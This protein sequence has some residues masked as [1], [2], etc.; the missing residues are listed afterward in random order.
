MRFY[1]CLVF[2][3]LVAS[4][5]KD[6]NQP[7]RKTLF[8]RLS[9]SETGISF[10]NAVENQGDF[11][12]FSYRNFYN[13]GGVGIGD[14][15]NDGLVDIY[16]SGNQSPNKLYLNQG[17][18]K[19]KDISKTAG[20]EGNKLWST[21]VTMVDINYDGFLD[22]YVSNAGY[23]KGEDQENELFINNGDLTFTEKASEYGLDDNG[24]TTHAAF[25]D[26]D[27]DGDLDAYILNNSFI[28]VNSLNY[29]DK[30]DLYAEDWDVMDFVKGGGDK[31]LR[32][33]NGKY[34]DVSKTAGI[35]GS[36]IGFGLGIT[37]GDVNND[38][39][40]DMYV[41]NDFFERDYLYINQGDG[42]FKE[43]IEEW[44]GHISLA[45][46]GADMADLNNDG[47]PEIF[48]TE[49][50]PET[51]ELVKQK[52]QFD[53][54]NIFNL[55]LKR[56]FH[57][58]FMHNTLQ[59]NTGNQYFK[60]IAWYSGVAASDWSWGALMFD[61]DNDGYR[62]I[63][64]CNGVYQDVTDQD[65]IDF[66]ANEVVQDMVLTGVKEEM[67]KVLEKMPVNP[68]PNKLFHNNGNLTFDSKEN[69]FGFNEPSFSNGAAYAD[70]DNDGDLDL[71]VN[72][73]NQESFVYRN[74]TEES[75]NHFL[76]LKL[77]GTTKNPFAIGSKAYVYQKNQV[78][79]TE[80]N[81]TR[82]FQSSVDY[83][84]YFGLGSES[85]IDSV[86]V[87]W[88]DQ[89]I[90]TIQNPQSDQIISI[91]Y[92]SSKKEL[93]E[94][95][96]AQ[97]ALFSQ[98]IGKLLK[99]EEDAFVDFYNE[100]LII[101]K[102][103]NEGPPLV[104]ADLNNDGLDDV[105]LGGA[106]GQPTQVFL[107]D[108][109]GSFNKSFSI[110]ESDKYEDTSLLLFD[111]D[112]D[113]DLDLFAGSGGNH[114]Q[115]LHPH[116]NDRLYI[117]NGQG[118]F[119]RS[120]QSL[121]ESGL[122]TAVAVSLDYD[123]DNDLD[124]FVGNRSIPGNY[125]SSPKSFLYENDGKGNFTDVTVRRAREL[126]EIGMVTD[127]KLTDIDGDSKEELIIVGE[128]MAPVVFKIENRQLKKVETN[129]SKSSGW[130]YA[131]NTDDVDGDGDMDL[132]LGNRGENFYFSATEEAPAKLWLQD[133]DDN[134][135]VEKLITKS[136]K[137]KDLPL[138]LKKELTQEI[139]IL[140]KENLKH[141]DYSNKTIHDLFDEETLKKAIVKE[142]TFFKSAIAI[143]NGKGDFSLKPLPMEAQLSNIRSIQVTDINKDGKNDLLVVGNDSGF[144]P[145][146]SRL[147]ANRG[148]VLINKGQGSFEALSPAKTGLNIKGDARHI[149]PINVKGNLQF[150]VTLNDDFPIF[151]KLD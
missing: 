46:M 59:L 63:Y 130:W 108:R 8:E 128:W 87:V 20:V 120:N 146:Y 151:L 52:S 102:L 122:N 67:S 80:L 91:S 141:V 1:T 61:V 96:P 60:E 36:L 56:G 33:E 3:V 139:P 65:F 81:P 4:C 119:N 84:L 123:N 54:Y 127:A 114:L 29:N 37:V 64:V 131:I 109:K 27:L 134:G 69:Q 89:T 50:L 11:N 129:L 116:L 7:Q 18:F 121:P 15:N 55:K 75:K 132:I 58:Q 53:S 106:S 145:Q 110:L 17:D 90:T 93:L 5:A 68:Q 104:V 62:D 2:I 150:I 76:A 6:P 47:L 105:V 115:V 118:T 24:F 94:N 9:A 142:A 143:N 107:Q 38:N 97:K 73:L 85:A 92:A 49:M 35:Y 26:Y 117:N 136:V 86:R 147:D 140:K 34:I 72:N 41:S 88:P 144:S 83:R 101:K 43:K 10:F 13:G 78:K 148:I 135:T 79:V 113:G 42:T 48:V 133:F 66:F 21:G 45:S 82:G 39:L 124:L 77:T 138:T 23:S 25:F 51:D 71:V 57:Y 28:P 12:I 99:H 40:P 112:G 111:I 31:L 16:F 98:K 30:R 100:G 125:G 74:N 137:G 22:I 19:F 95:K 32:N 44:T 126:R 149:V 103:S 70:L 14:I